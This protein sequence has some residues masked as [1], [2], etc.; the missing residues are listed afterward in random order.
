MTCRF[1]NDTGRHE[2]LTSV[3]DCKECLSSNFQDAAARSQLAYNTFFGVPFAPEDHVIGPASG[4]IQQGI[5]A[6][7]PAPEPEPV[8][9][10]ATQYE[11]IWGP[12]MRRLALDRRGLHIDGRA[13]ARVFMSTSRSCA[14]DTRDL[15]SVEVGDIVTIGREGENRRI[16]TLDRLTGHIGFDME[17]TE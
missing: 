6:W 13:V 5:A 3:V 8:G 17:W 10:S 4:T 7:V 9:L 11:N 2:L 12:T 15:A 16:G 14:A 1:C